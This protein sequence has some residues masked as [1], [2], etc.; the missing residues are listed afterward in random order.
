[1]QSILNFLFMTLSLT[2]VPVYGA[3]VVF[4]PVKP[5]FVMC[6]C[7]GV[8]ADTR[9]TWGTA[10][11]LPTRA[12][13]T[14]TAS[15]T[16]LSLTQTSVSISPQYRNYG[17]FI[18]TGTSKGWID[19]STYFYNRSTIELLYVL[20]HDYKVPDVVGRVLSAWSSDAVSSGCSP[21]NT[22]SPLLSA[23]NLTDLVFEN[24]NFSEPIETRLLPGRHTGMY[25]IEI[26][27]S[28]TDQTC[29]SMSH[30]YF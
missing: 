10:Y 26:P 4:Q 3:S 17:V 19:Q 2:T 6:G 16:T 7:T 18:N 27:E 15:I 28:L 14:H 12:L 24:I 22:P 20:S 30:H 25:Q 21:S 11:M 29:S 8:F 13:S 1:M 5:N 23:A 9:T